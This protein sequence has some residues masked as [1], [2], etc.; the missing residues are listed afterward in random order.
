MTNCIKNCEN[1]RKKV[2]ENCL[3]TTHKLKYIHMQHF[4]VFCSDR[5]NYIHAYGIFID[6]ICQRY[7]IIF[8]KKFFQL[9]LQLYYNNA[10][11]NSIICSNLEE[12]EQISTDSESC[13]VNSYSHFYEE[14]TFY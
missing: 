6:K 5:Y 14:D 3:Q 12:S 13:K 11:P 2:S 10:V 7:V 1:S 8:L 4:L 9:N